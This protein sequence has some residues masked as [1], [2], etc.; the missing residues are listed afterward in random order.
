[1]S[2]CIACY[3][4]ERVSI[5]CHMPIHVTMWL[6][7]LCMYQEKGIL[8][9]HCTLSRPPRSLPAHPP[10]AAWLGPALPSSCLVC[11]DLAALQLAPLAAQHAASQPVG[12]SGG[13]KAVS[14]ASRASLHRRSFHKLC[15]S[16]LPFLFVL[17]STYRL[18]QQQHSDRVHRGTTT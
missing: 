7:V 1:M 11:L 8:R 2:C 15:N 3:M 18:R 12:V 17:G 4:C 14:A 16:P 5:Q 10:S 9:C 6:Q 13:Q